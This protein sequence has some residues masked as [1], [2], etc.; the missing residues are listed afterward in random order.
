[1]AQLLGKV[2]VLEAARIVV[3]VDVARPPAELLRAGTARSPQSGRRPN[4][5]VFPDVRGRF[6]E[7]DVGRIRFRRSCQVD[8]G[9]CK[10]QTSL[11]EADV[12]HGLRSGDGDQQRAR[13]G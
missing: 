4:L 10:V 8:R 3:W 12:L 7:R 6:L 9:L 11:R 13:V 1:P 2:V 5:T